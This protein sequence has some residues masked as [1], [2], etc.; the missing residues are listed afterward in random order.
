MAL[1]TSKKAIQR[2]TNNLLKDNYGH[3]REFSIL[4]GILCMTCGSDTEDY[5]I[6]RSIFD[7]QRIATRLDKL[8]GRILDVKALREHQK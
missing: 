4:H 6:L 2:R 5:E 7:M 8:N 3:E 1:D